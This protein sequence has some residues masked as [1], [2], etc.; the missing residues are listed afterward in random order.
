M[1]AAPARAPAALRGAARAL[2][3]LGA[4]LVDVAR[5]EAVL[6]R[7]P[8]LAAAL[9]TPRE[10]AAADAGARPAEALALC[11][12]AKEALLKALGRGLASTG[13]DRAL[14]EIEVARGPGFPVPASGGADAA[15]LRLTGGTAARVAAR[16]ASPVLALAS[17]SGH[18]LATV[19]LLPA[20]ASAELV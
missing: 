18:A 2:P 13:P 15:G 1:S 6:A 10:R 12:A 7:T 16:G 4:D 3:A 14:L 9:F 5:L 20:P 19:L 17:A 8:G 11:F